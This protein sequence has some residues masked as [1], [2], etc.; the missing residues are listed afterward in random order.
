MELTIEQLDKILFESTEHLTEAQ[1]ELLI[2]NRLEFIKANNKDKISVD[3]DPESANLS[4][5]K[6]VDTIAKKVD[7]T[8]KKNHTEWLVNRYKAGD[9]KLGDT[10]AVKKTINDFEELSGRL[11]NKDLKSYR[12]LTDLR[13]HIATTTI[14]RK[15]NKSDEGESVAGET[16]LYNAEGVTGSKINSKS[17]SIAN[18]GPSGKVAKTSWCTAAAGNNN[19]FAGYKGGKYVMKFPNGRVLQF[20]HETGQLKDEHNRNID[21][22]VDPGYKD[23]SEH[24]KN[25][26]KQTAEKDDVKESTG[27]K[28]Y[29]GF[30][31]EEF[32]HA[33]NEHDKSTAAI[34]QHL[35]QSADKNRI[36]LPH[37]LHINS[38]A[39]YGK[40]P[41]M[42]ARADIS[43]Q[44][45]ERIQ[46]AKEWNNFDDKFKSGKELINMAIAKNKF[47]KPE[48]LNKL[49][50]I[51]KN[52]DFDSSNVTM[53][54]DIARNPNTSDETLHKL[55]G[56][57]ADIDKATYYG[58][59][60]RSHLIAHSPNMKEEHF[61]RLNA[62]TDEMADAIKMSPSKHIPHSYYNM[63]KGSTTILA[64][65][66]HL[67]N[68]ISEHVA[69]NAHQISD[70]HVKDFLENPTVPMEH[71][72]K[73]IETRAA[74]Q[75]RVPF[76]LHAV[77]NRPD[78]TPQDVTKMVNHFNA[79]EIH[80][81]N[82]SWAASNR[83]SRDDIHSLIKGPHVGELL[84]DY[85]RGLVSNPKLRHGE[86]HDIINHPDFKIG[87]VMSLLN[88]GSMRASNVDSIM[89][90]FGA[91]SHHVI[92]QSENKAIQPHHI[93]KILKEPSNS[94]FTHTK[95]LM[96]HA[97]APE[98]FKDSLSNQKLHGAISV[99]PNAPPSVLHS[100]V[101][102]PHEFVRQNLAE[103]PNTNK[104]DTLKILATDANESIADA[105]KK[106]LK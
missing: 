89:D 37:Q 27:L 61:N 38:N 60:L 33:L 85:N 94:V 28:S 84:N 78:V 11:P 69:N 74:N 43:D 48:H 42:A 9:F 12:S 39:T 19:M 76:S 91:E 77:I 71:I 88:S 79:G 93:S 75:L 63:F 1:L 64:Q 20:H 46:H 16:E 47:A 53:D 25:F 100:L 99:S 13:D 66:K 51:T 15:M 106:R 65:A 26:V 32:E 40:L 10:K 62:E 97:N 70:S 8:T 98:H 90:K 87:H 102:S 34:Q 95:A 86:I 24:I 6:I 7:P 4:S 2:E 18:Y 58:K 14:H 5:D 96:H 81:N 59:H 52:E 41:L 56:K 50:D 67:P 22:N 30:T 3:H 21:V 101:A 45:F 54:N 23:Y 44:Q 80:P 49:A 82:H 105:A 57:V 55:V 83:L 17:A 73:A 103:N 72:H 35:D 36:W 104:E 31:N 29:I 68:D 92:A